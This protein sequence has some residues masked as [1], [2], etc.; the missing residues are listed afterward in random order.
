MENDLEARQ[1]VLSCK[2]TQAEWGGRNLYG[3][4]PICPELHH[5]AVCL[6][7]VFFTV[8][9]TSLGALHWWF[10]SHLV[11]S[12]DTVKP[13][14]SIRT[15]S[16]AVETNCTVAQCAVRVF[17]RVRPAAGIDDE[18]RRH[19]TDLIPIKKGI[20]AFWNC[21]WLSNSVAFGCD[22]RRLSTTS[23][24]SSVNL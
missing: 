18:W 1:I 15:P 5:L 13:L 9:L 16:N 8:I 21:S 10:T 20:W 7:C 4:K 22:A 2:S 19:V 12:E 3:V 23:S 14:K 24:T 17:M 6:P 11:D